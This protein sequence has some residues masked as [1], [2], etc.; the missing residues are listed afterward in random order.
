MFFEVPVKGDRI[1]ELTEAF[2]VQLA[3]DT[4][5]NSNAGLLLERS[6]GLGVIHPDDTGASLDHGELVV[7]GTALDDVTEVRSVDGR[8]E[9]QFNAEL[10]VFDRSLV[11]AFF[12]ET[13]DGADRIH[14][15]GELTGVTAS[16]HLGDDDD[17][18]S[19]VDSTLGESRIIAGG[20]ND[21]VLTNDANQHV[22]GGL[23]DDRIVTGA[24]ADSVFGD[25]GA[26]TLASG[27][28]DDSVDGGEGSDLS[29]IHI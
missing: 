18:L 15:E 13:G 24:G 14:F 3:I 10:S 8:V 4:E 25:E 26:D 28:G 16:V 27:L 19:S 23:G 20:G 9:V 6:T 5:F 2:G 21:V 12:A 7:F 11:D 22:R 29:L 17:E 1:V